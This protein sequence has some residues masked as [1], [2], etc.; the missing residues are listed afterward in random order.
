MPYN[1]LQNIRDIIVALD[2]IKRLNT[3]VG[4][5]INRLESVEGRIVE[6]EKTAAVKDA[7]LKSL[8]DNVEVTTTATL[9]VAASKIESQFLERVLRLESAVSLMQSQN[10]NSERG[11]RQLKPPKS[12]PPHST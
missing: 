6:L 10:T 9:R 8:K 4:K 11:Q 12:T 3:N 2:E 5:L 1:P 7:E